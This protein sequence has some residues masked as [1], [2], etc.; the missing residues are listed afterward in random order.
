MA[1]YTIDQIPEFDRP[2]E[3]MIHYGPDFLSTAE[4]IAAI[5][6]SGTKGISV[7]DLAHELTYLYGNKLADVTIEELCQVKGMG[8]A[9]AVQLKAALSLGMR[10]MK[11]TMPKKQRLLNPKDVHAFIKDEL[12]REQ[13]ELLVAIFLDVRGCVICRKIVTIGTLSRTLIHPREVFY[14]A[15]RHNASSLILVHNHPS[16]DPTPSKEDLLATENL[17]AV[18]KMMGIPVYDHLIVGHRSYVSL[19]EKGF[20]F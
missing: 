10:A 20:K 7:M 4:L 17:V 18:G 5:L 12:E 8:K 6:G 9:K 11:T 13:R 14:F 15:I 19:R 16:G 3:R 2:R 1:S